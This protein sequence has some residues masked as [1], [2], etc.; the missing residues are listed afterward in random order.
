MH[1]NIIQAE[2]FIYTKWYNDEDII[3]ATI[4][5]NHSFMYQE[6]NYEY[7]VSYTEHMQMGHPYRIYYNYY[8][9]ITR[10]NLWNSLLTKW[11]VTMM[12]KYL[13]TLKSRQ[14]TDRI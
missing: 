7:T 2:Y 3:T 14:N 1:N 9:I 4:N 12:M 10:V 11:S 13:A 5:Q 8:I 6:Q